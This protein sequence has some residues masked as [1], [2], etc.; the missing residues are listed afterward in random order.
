MISGKFNNANKKAV[1]LYWMAAFL[2]PKVLYA[3]RT[4]PICNRTNF[5]PSKHLYKH[6][7]GDMLGANTPLPKY[8]VVTVP[9][10]DPEAPTLDEL[11]L[12]DQVMDWLGRV[13]N[14]LDLLEKKLNPEQDVDK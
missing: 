5:D 6:Q 4:I 2:F 14:H 13:F 12:S 7:G 10:N 8:D 3:I 1:V 11:C 9:S